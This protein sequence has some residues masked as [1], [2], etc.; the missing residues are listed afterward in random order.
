MT[1]LAS[2]L[3]EGYFPRELPPPFGSARYGKFAKAV[4]SLWPKNTWTRC[5]EHNLAR[6]G[7]IRRPLKIPNPLSYFALA[8][9]VAKNWAKIKQFTLQ[10][11]LSASRPYRKASSGRAVIMR[12]KYSELPRIRALRWRAGRYLLQTDINQ[13]YPTIYTHSI[14]WALHTKAASKASLRSGKRVVR[15]GDELDALL[16]N[17]N[18]GQTHGIPIGPDTSLIVAEILLAAADQA[19]I[20]KHGNQFSG[21]RYIDDYELAFQASSAAEETLSDLQAVLASFELIINPKKT[22]IVDLPFRLDTA[23]AVELKAPT[24]RIREHPVAQRNDILMLFS[25]AFDLA[26]KY[27]EE[28]VLRYAVARVQGT[29]IDPSGWRSFHNCVLSAAAADP[30]TLPVALGTLYRVAS[31]GGHLVPKAPLGEVFESV[32]GRHAALA[33]GSEIAWALWGALSW[34]VSLSAD[35]A[36]LVSNMDDDIVA[37]LALHLDAEGLFPDGALRKDNWAALVA[38]PDALVGE[39]WLLAY[40]ANKQG[41]LHAASIAK[42]R[43]FSSMSAAAVSF[44]DKKKCAP[45]FPDAGRAMPGGLLWSNY[46]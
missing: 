9:V 27:P 21:F 24:I 37:L 22:R 26:A 45:Q 16:R 36:R 39:H 38:Q 8:H 1:L 30:S 17:M 6:P 13:F 29:D 43:E 2:L 28:S 14:P 31:R 19:L 23:W 46:A 33:Q 42:N 18:D 15:L 32:I 3:S 10:E 25:R 41:W 5:V 11:R 35:A 12:Y 7:G 20:A 40:E 44:Y 4:G 34:S